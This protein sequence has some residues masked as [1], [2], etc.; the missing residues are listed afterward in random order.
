MIAYVD[1]GA[2]AVGDWVRLELHQDTSGK[3]DQ[4]LTVMGVMRVK[5]VDPST[6]HHIEPMDEIEF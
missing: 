6:Q 1:R 4:R 5:R 2:V 3:P